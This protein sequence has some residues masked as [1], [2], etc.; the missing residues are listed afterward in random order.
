M[1]H[2]SLA[3]SLVALLLA[4]LIAPTAFFSYATPVR[5]VVV[6]VVSDTSATSF[7]TAAKSAISAIQD[8]IS[9]VKATA[10]H[11]LQITETA[12]EY[13]QYIKAYILD[14]LA[15][16]MGGN[17]QKSITSSI[18]NFVNKNKLYVQ[19]LPG[20]LQNVGDVQAYAFLNQ[21]SSNSN[22]PFASTIT[23]SLRA[24]YLQQTSMAGFFAANR[25]TLSQSSPNYRSFLAGNWSQ[26]GTSAWFALTTQDQ[27]NPYLLYYRAQD[28][29]TRSVQNMAAAKLA[30]LNWGK[31][32]L[33]WCGSGVNTT[34]S[35]GSGEGGGYGGGDTID[36]SAPTVLCEAHCQS[37]HTCVQAGPGGCADITD[38]TY[39]LPDDFSCPSDAPFDPYS[40][41]C[42][43]SDG[44]IT[45]PYDT[46]GDPAY[47]DGTAGTVSC[48]ASCPGGSTCVPAGPAGC[49]DTTLHTYILP[50]GF[51]CPSDAPF[52]P[53]SGGCQYSDGLTTYPKTP[54]GAAT[55]IASAATAY[56]GTPTN[57]GPDAGNLA[58]AWAVNNVLKNAGIASIDGNSVALMEAELKAGRGTLVSQSDARAGDIVVLNTGSGVGDRRHVGFCENDGCTSTISN[59][60]SRAAFV[61]RNDVT[62]GSGIPTRIYRV[63]GTTALLGGPPAKVAVVTL[64]A[65][66]AAKSSVVGSAL[67]YVWNLAP[68][69]AASHDGGGGGGGGGGSSFAKIPQP[70]D[71]CTKPDGTQG[72]IQTPGSIIK[73]YLSEVLGANIPKLVNDM[74]S[75]SASISRIM[76]NISTVMQTVDMA[77]GLFGADGGLG[78]VGSTSSYDSP[79]NT[80]LNSSAYMGLS[81]SDIKDP[82]TVID[83][84]KEAAAVCDIT[85]GPSQCPSGTVCMANDSFSTAG[86]CRIPPP[87]AALAASPTSIASGQ[88]SVLTWSSAYATSCIGTG[89]STEGAISGSVSVS[90][91]VTTTYSVTCT[92][93]GGTSPP[94][95]ATVQVDVP[96]VTL[97]AS[98]DLIEG[99]QSS[100]LTWSS[101]RATSCTGTEFST[102]GA[103]SGSVS[104]YPSVTTT[105]SVTC[106][107]SGGTSP[108]SS[109]TV[110]VYAPPP[111]P[112]SE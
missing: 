15:F 12:A 85:L 41:G 28:Q 93:A 40:G 90:P 23:S 17:L 71:P 11:L 10:S 102:E 18:L 63:T 32:F 55:T 75:I 96:T 57:L 56:V 7:E 34:S 84:T 91:L 50:D 73:D 98:P 107:G 45:V 29:M 53:Y 4:A 1:S 16:L 72:R 109:A 110:Q 65:S 74:S 105:Y 101:A 67:G 52:D 92:G 2:S 44:Y 24:N 81:A 51:S 58:C 3:K 80:Y 59:S 49:A 66:G 25:N 27:N 68:T 43:Y 69:A 35:L 38:H 100:V 112:E 21:F 5:A 9:A 36:G 60:S 13:A 86:T 104:V 39:I 31:G 70:G 6:E 42:Q 94:A 14:P 64:P 77:A 103:T 47:G 30:Q 54:A 89:F 48:T 20:Y 19:N 88:S 78:S 87:L 108:A 76:S 46:S 22:S 106:T 79:F 82:G 99:G 26:G 83:Y 37:G 111:P 95:S 62:L 61:N 33:S 8:T 97:T